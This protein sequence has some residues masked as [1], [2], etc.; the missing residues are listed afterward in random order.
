MALMMA[1][2]SESAKN[3]L[4]N[5]IAKHDRKHLDISPNLYDYWTNSLIKAVA[6]FDPNFNPKLETEWRKAI[7]LTVD[8][9]K[10]GY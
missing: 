1:N 10:N 5:L 6:E 9:F 7:Q 4:S 2:G 3:T 8:L